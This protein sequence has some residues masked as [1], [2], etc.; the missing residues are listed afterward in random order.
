VYSLIHFGV[1]IG[2]VLIAILCGFTFWTTRPRIFVR[3][4]LD[5]RADVP[6]LAA[7][8]DPVATA[9]GV[10]V[11]RVRLTTRFTAY[12]RA[13]GI[14]RRPALVL[15]VPML[16]VLNGDE[17]IAL[18]GHE[19]GHLVNHDPTSSLVMGAALSIIGA[20]LDVLWPRVQVRRPGKVG[21]DLVYLIMRFLG[22]I[23]RAYGALMVR[24]IMASSRHA[25]LHADVI[26]SR[27][28]GTRATTDM[29]EK[30][31]A[32]G[33]TFEFLVELAALH[34]ER[35]GKLAEELGERTASYDA[36]HRVLS[37]TSPSPWRSH[38][39]TDV[40]VRALAG[41]ND[42][43]TVRES[44]ADTQELDVALQGRMDEVEQQAVTDYQM[45]H[46]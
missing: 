32:S 40:R 41:R 20:W 11:D 18:V 21:E 46:R 23:V 27:V 6:S 36:G 8:V 28:A 13:E 35:R 16:A 31:E 29:L 37:P 44:A 5:Q 43:A 9:M 10:R 25:E 22:G 12:V 14:R 45:T 30:V 39:P 26:A 24:P 33:V 17:R 42:P 34:P 19:V 7:L 1:H 3:R 38:P 4:G 15:G 2:S